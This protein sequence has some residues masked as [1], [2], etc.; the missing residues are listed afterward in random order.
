[1]GTVGF[2]EERLIPGKDEVLWGIGIEHEVILAYKTMYKIKAS[3]QFRGYELISNSSDKEM[4]FYQFIDS[5]FI[6]QN[7]KN[8][9]GFEIDRGG[10]LAYFEVKT[11]KYKNS[12]ITDIITELE[13]A[14]NDLVTAVNNL[15]IIRHIK[16]ENKDMNN[17]VRIFDDFGVVS[18]GFYYHSTEGLSFISPKTGSYHLNLTLPFTRNMDPH[19]FDV[20]NIAFAWILQ[21]VTPLFISAYMSVDPIAIGQCITVDKGKWTKGSYR[22]ITEMTSSSGMIDVR[23]LKDPQPMR[24]IPITSPWFAKV[25]NDTFNNI[26]WYNI[27]LDNTIGPV[28]FRREIVNNRKYDFDRVH[29]LSKGEAFGFEFRIFD[30]FPLRYMEDLLRFIFY[31]ADHSFT[32]INHP[33]SKFIDPRMDPDWQDAMDGVFR[34]GWLHNNSKYL[35]KIKEVLILP[36]NLSTSSRLYDICTSLSDYLFQEYNSK[37]TNFGE[38]SQFVDQRF[39]LKR[40]KIPQINRQ[41]WEHIFHTLP[42]RHPLVTQ[43]NEIAMVKKPKTIKEI[44]DMFS[45][46]SCDTQH[47]LYLGESLGIWKVDSNTKTLK[48]YNHGKGKPRRWYITDTE[49]QHYLEQYYDRDAFIPIDI[50]DFNEKMKGWLQSFFLV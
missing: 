23:T 36:E 29:N 31:L 47:F 42:E 1:M 17:D 26:Y 33:G 38:Y 16:K 27:S 24:Q 6:R 48:Y 12:G 34:Q 18:N 11:K 5:Q 35:N 9:Y 46:V 22:N 10:T 37:G 43:F 4:L 3:P 40:P 20:R 45:N 41:S 21:W 39:G 50:I 44:E 15:E 2:K 14:E 32:I 19:H 28:D 25:Q 13:K 8:L 7:E 30:N 49:N